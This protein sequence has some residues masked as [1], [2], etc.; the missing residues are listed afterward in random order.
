MIDRCANVTVDEFK[1]MN[2]KWE[3]DHRDVIV[4]TINR[5]NEECKV[6]ADSANISVARLYELVNQPVDPPSFE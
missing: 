3:K 6:L 1:A 2:E 5:V 4:D